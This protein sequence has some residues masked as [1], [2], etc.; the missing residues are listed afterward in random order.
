MRGNELS[1]EYDISRTYETCLHQTDTHDLY[2][3]ELE[4]LDLRITKS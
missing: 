1:C 2:L 4:E 3:V